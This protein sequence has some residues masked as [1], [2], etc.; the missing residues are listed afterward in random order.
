[1]IGI[2]GMASA[3]VMSEPNMKSDAAGVS[4]SGSMTRSRAKS[5]GHG[6]CGRTEEE[7]LLLQ[8][9]QQ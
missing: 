5:V 8:Y 9:H 2:R 1:M 4:N 7:A 6:S 3:K